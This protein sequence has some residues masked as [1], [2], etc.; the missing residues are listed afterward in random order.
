MPWMRMVGLVNVFE[1]PE[2]FQSWSSTRLLKKLSYYS[3]RGKVLAGV[4]DQKQNTRQSVLRV[5]KVYQC[6]TSEI[7]DGAQCT[8]KTGGQEHGSL[9]KIQVIQG[10]END[11]WQTEQ[12]LVDKKIA[13]RYNTGKCKI[14]YRQ[15]NNSNFTCSLNKTGLFT[16]K[17][18]KLKG[19]YR[20][21]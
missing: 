13:N 17:K 15:K 11:R 20:G 4:R 2:S 8:W 18:R 5:D 21:L 10:G 7:S 3:S 1:V 12:V 16:L 19:C 14:M 6:R 9:L